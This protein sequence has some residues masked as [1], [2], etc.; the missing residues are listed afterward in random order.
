SIATPSVPGGLTRAR[1][2][3]A[4][5]ACWMTTRVRL[6]PLALRTVLP[7]DCSS[8]G[9]CAGRRGA[10]PCGWPCT[11]APCRWRDLA[12]CEL[13]RGC[14]DGHGHV[15]HGPQGAGPLRRVELSSLRDMESAQT[16]AW[17]RT[18]GTEVQRR[19]PQPASV[20]PWT[21]QRA[22]RGRTPSWDVRAQQLPSVGAPA[23]T[24]PIPV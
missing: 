18:Y 14:G 9:C 10:A 7:S 5:C 8:H 12:T 3:A 19:G 20:H 11:R 6:Q 24:S 1:R 2:G 23:G 16:D 13:G 21:C 4:R 22:H 15:H 17:Y